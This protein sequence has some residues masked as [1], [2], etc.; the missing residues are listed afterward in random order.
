[1]PLMPEKSEFAR[2]W[3]NVLSYHMDQGIGDPIVAYEFM[4]RFY[5]LEG[6]K[7]VSVLKYMHADSI[8]GSVTRIIPYPENTLENRIYYEFLDF[9]KESQINYIWFSQAGSFR[10][11]SDALGKK[12][13]EKWTDEEL[14][15]IKNKKPLCFAQLTTPIESGAIARIEGAE[16]VR[17]DRA[18]VDCLQYY[19]EGDT[20]PESVIGTL[21]QHL[22]RI[23]MITDT[24]SELMAAIDRIQ[25]SIRVT[26]SSGNEMYRKR[27]DVS[28]LS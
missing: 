23:S 14:E 16:A 7:R 11:L 3:D 6:N 12:P 13:V 8:E 17:S 2:K 19:K 28:R 27:F 25:D 9:Y 26:D 18:V 24:E 5:V 4:N 20:V 15:R 1:M 10:K 21:G 22:F